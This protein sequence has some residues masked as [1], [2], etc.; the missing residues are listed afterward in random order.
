MNLTMSK[1]SPYSLTHLPSPVPP[2]AALP[3]RPLSRRDFFMKRERGRFVAPP[4]LHGVK[5]EMCK[6]VAY[7]SCHVCTATIQLTPKKC[8]VHSAHLLLH[9]TSSRNSG[10]KMGQRQS[11]RNP[12]ITGRS[13]KGVQEELWIHCSLSLSSC[14]AVGR[15]EED[16]SSS[17]SSWACSR[18]RTDQT[19]RRPLRSSSG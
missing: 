17:S 5:N 8:S 1:H 9:L 11:C 2:T 7:G 3:P 12:L 13:R 15:K 19:P 16:P 10:C 4:S 18:A 14:G 6:I